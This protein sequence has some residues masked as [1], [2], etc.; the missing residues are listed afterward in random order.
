MNVKCNIRHFWNTC[1]CNCIWIIAKYVVCTNKN[2]LNYKVCLTCCAVQTQYNIG[3]YYILDL[4]IRSAE[5]TNIN[6][7]LLLFII[8]WSDDWWAETIIRL[9]TK[10][11]QTVNWWHNFIY[12]FPLNF[13]S[14]IASHTLAWTFFGAKKCVCV[15]L[16][17]QNRKSIKQILLF[18]LHSPPL[19]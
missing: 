2:W 14:Q 5:I 17:I 13:L 6:I 3:L 19:K 9:L 12:P 16:T 4:K 8:L 1:T 11:G 10:M 18:T 15:L 7:M